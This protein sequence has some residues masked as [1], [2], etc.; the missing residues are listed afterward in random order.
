MW[1]PLPSPHPPPTHRPCHPDATLPT[2]P[3]FPC[4]AL[5][6]HL[7]TV[8]A[9]LLFPPSPA[10]CWTA[11]TAS[12]PSAARASALASWRCWRTS[13]GE[14]GGGC[15]CLSLCLASVTV[16]RKHL[17]RCWRTSRGEGEGAVKCG[18]PVLCLAS[19]SVLRKHAL[20]SALE[21]LLE[22]KP[23]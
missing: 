15:L 4:P 8:P 1:R 2:H 18:V 13:L 21:L 23:R 22:N 10:A 14:G 3:P 11:P 16:L 17:R 7:H 12:W 20:R 5:P 6:T 19:A 9:Y